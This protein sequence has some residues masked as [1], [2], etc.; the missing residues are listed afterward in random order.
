MSVILYWKKRL[1][2]GNPLYAESLRIQNYNIKYRD[3]PRDG[4]PFAV[5]KQGLYQDYCIWHR[6]EMVPTYHDV[7]YFRDNEDQIPVAAA[8]LFF[9]TTIAPFLYIVDSK[10]QTRSYQVND[11]VIHEG[12]A[13]HVKKGRN[14][15]R[16][17]TLEEHRAA[18]VIQTGS[19]VKEMIDTYDPEKY[20]L[21]GEAI[22][23]V[24]TVT[25]ERREA[26]A[27]SME[28]KEG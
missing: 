23:R 10:V 21:M 15:V 13:V 2:E 19:P 24:R 25:D 9:F 3:G 12:E 7:P 4:W 26:M 28:A 6:D 14:F 27:R 18:Y 1:Q 17:C 20:R 16:L 22:D 5:A 8:E 11:M